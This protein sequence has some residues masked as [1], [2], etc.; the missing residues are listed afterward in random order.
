M[1]TALPTNGLLALLLA[2]GT[3]SGAAAQEPNPELA[4]LT[5]RLHGLDADPAN[6]NAA[7]LER[8]QAQQALDALAA[9][10]RGDV[11][12][13]LQIAQWRVETAEL[14]VDTALARRQIE[15]LERERSEWLLEASR[16]EAER[17]RQEAERLRIQAQIQTEETERLR[18][19]AEAEAQARQEAETRLD[20]AAGTQAERLRAARQR[21]EELQ[22]Q[23]DALRKRLE[24][25]SQ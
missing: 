17:A 4:P 8:L 6:A 7:A 19:L 14:A 15:A 20:E 11:P 16:R 23:E 13:A 25:E 24:R 5:H 3:A 22:R 1:N 21:A 18:Q 12:G 9:A 2:L 10:R